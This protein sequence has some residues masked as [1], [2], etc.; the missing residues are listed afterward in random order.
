MMTRKLALCI[1]LS[2][3][4][5]LVPL[6]AAAQTQP[7]Q[8]G[9]FSPD[10]IQWKD[11]P[12]ALPPGAKVAVLEGD[13][14]QEGLFT[15]R[16]RVPKGYRI[17]PHWH[18]AFEHVTVISGAFHMGMGETFDAS[19]GNRIP[20]G[21]FSWMA[22]GARHF[23]WVEEDTIVQVHGMGPWQL[24]YVNPADDPRT[25]ASKPAAK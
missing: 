8:H 11:A 17:P 2:I 21:G 20:T 13:P 18:P 6:A 15:M 9:F 19:K 24:Y 10:Q 1:L 5:L 23:A 4:C 14:G 22:P 25:A 12:P 16:L 7:P 3:G